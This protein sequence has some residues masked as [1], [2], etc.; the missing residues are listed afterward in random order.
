MNRNRGGDGRVDAAAE[1][2]HHAFETAF[3]QVIA[4]AEAQRLE[5]FLWFAHGAAPGKERSVAVHDLESFL[6]C[7]ELCEH[8]AACCD[9]Q[10]VAIEHQLVV[11][12]RRVAIEDGDVMPRS[13]RGEHFAAPQWFADAERGGT[14]VDDEFRARFDQR[15]QRIEIVQPPG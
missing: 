9:G 13:Q 10:R 8:A 2:Q 5:K 12:S 15:T 4:Q 6:K 1:S 7:R 3:A 11:A 14:D